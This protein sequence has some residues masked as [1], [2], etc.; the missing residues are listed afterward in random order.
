VGDVDEDDFEG[1][2]VI[3]APVQHGAGNSIGLASTSCAQAADPI[4]GV[5]IP[6][7]TRGDDVSSGGPQ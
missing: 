4:E 6:S 7:P 5:I 3:Q 2:L 1:G